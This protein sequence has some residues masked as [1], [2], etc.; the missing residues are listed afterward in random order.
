[1][2]GNCQHGWDKWYEEHEKEKQLI[3][4]YKEERQAPV[5]A[6]KEKRHFNWVKYG[7]RNTRR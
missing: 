2:K 6:A 5:T 3:R 7:D 1:M 4:A